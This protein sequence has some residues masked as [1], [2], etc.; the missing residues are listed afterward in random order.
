MQRRRAGRRGRVPWLAAAPQR[1]GA[2]A[3]SGRALWPTRYA[4]C[5]HRCR[6]HLRSPRSSRC[7]ALFFFCCC[8]FSASKVRGS[9]SL[10]STPLPDAP[11]S[12]AERFRPLPDAP[13]SVAERCRPRR[14]RCGRCPRGFGDSHLIVSRADL[15]VSQPGCTHVRSRA[16]VTPAGGV[17]R[18]SASRAA[19][20][21]AKRGSRRQSPSPT[22][23]RPSPPT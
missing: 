12:V 2:M 3:R 10:L 5:C 23:L 18:A 14:G 17:Q 16:H 1:L 20:S 21:A 7:A 9:W 15:P 8:P 4:A 6:S 19:E 22:P 13:A 11:A